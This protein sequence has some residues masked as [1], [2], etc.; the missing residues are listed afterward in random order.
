MKV[1][2]IGVVRLGEPFKPFSS[3]PFPPWLREKDLR[4][5]FELDGFGEGTVSW[6]GEVLEFKFPLGISGEREPYGFWLGMSLHVPAGIFP[7]AVAVSFPKYN[8]ELEAGVAPLGDHPEDSGTFIVR[9]FCRGQHPI[10]P[11][12]AEILVEVQLTFLESLTGLE[13]IDIEEMEAKADKEEELETLMKKVKELRDN[14]EGELA[15]V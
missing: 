13:D 1:H 14:D 10:F 8:L 4:C 2:E 3:F 9:F 5:R 7:P 6:Y 15:L 11:A 12:Q